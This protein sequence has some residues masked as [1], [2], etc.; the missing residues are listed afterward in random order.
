V[1]FE[2]CRKYARAYLDARGNFSARCPG[3]LASLSVR[4]P[5]RE[6]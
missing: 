3:C 5:T 4:A 6:R 1:F 2:C